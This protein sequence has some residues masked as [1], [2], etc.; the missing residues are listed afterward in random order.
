MSKRTYIWLGIIA[1][2]LALAFVFSPADRNRGTAAN[3][4]GGHPH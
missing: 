2:A 1:I 4:A 3:A